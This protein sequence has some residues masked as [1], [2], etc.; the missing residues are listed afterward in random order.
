[1]LYIKIEKKENGIHVLKLKQARPKD[2]GAYMCKA[3]NHAGSTKT[4]AN[5]VVKSMLKGSSESKPISAVLNFR[6]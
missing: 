3:S 2:S 5:L 1:M 6:R 4:S